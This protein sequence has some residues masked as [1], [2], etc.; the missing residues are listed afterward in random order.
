MLQVQKLM[1]FRT[2]RAAVM[3]LACLGLTSSA[4]A[5]KDE[6]NQG[7]WEKPCEKGPDKVVPGF[8]V[9][10]G[11]TGSRG[12]L[13]KNSLIVKFIFPDTPATGVLKID[14]EVVGANGKM[15]AEHTFGRKYHG[16][17]GPI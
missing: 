8:L 5:I 14:D 3:L 12:I 13:T 6:T 16:I 15:F 2:T 9:N 1:G 4:L 10:M 17:E 7:R 11:P